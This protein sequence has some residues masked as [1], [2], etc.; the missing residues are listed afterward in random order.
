MWWSYPQIY[1][2]RIFYCS[3]IFYKS[4]K[5]IKQTLKFH[6]F[7]IFFV[8]SS[9]VQ[10]TFNKV[11]IYKLSFD[12]DFTSIGPKR[13]E[14]NPRTFRTFFS[15][16]VSNKKNVHNLWTK[17]KSHIV[18]KIFCSKT[19]NKNKCSQFR[20]K[21][22]LTMARN[23]LYNRKKCSQFVNKKKVSHCEQKKMFT[24]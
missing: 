17:K 5:L 11:S 16:E 18:N 6:I 22:S 12:T 3:K 2:Y 15:L 19:V 8:S 1:F 10:K 23:H 4:K 14:K 24:I 13:T 7:V 21:K 20:T 9:T